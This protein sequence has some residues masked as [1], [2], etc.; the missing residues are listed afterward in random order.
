MR[1]FFPLPFDLPPAP[2]VTSA[3]KPSLR[4]VFFSSSP[5][6][7]V[8][9]SPHLLVSSSPR[10][11]FSSS[12]LLFSS[13]PLLLFSP[14]PLFL[15]SSSPLLLFS[16]SPLL[17]FS[18]SP[19]LLFSSSPLLLFSFSP[20]LSTTLLICTSL[21]P[22]WPVNPPRQQHPWRWDVPHRQPDVFGET[23]PLQGA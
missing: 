5:H 16:S 4:P 19:L 23:W 18:S 2:L 13:S 8:S 22:P 7:L 20:L 14:S 21:L 17:P 10:L 1:V 12:P 9:S 15:F 11:L 3:G 6:L